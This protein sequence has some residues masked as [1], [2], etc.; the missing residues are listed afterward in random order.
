MLHNVL[1]FNDSKEYRD[2]HGYQTMPTEHL[3]QLIDARV[4]RKDYTH[5]SRDVC[6]Q[7]LLTQI[8][9]ATSKGRKAFSFSPKDMQ[10]PFNIEEIKYYAG[11]ISIRKAEDG[12]RWWVYMSCHTYLASLIRPRSSY[13]N[14]VLTPAPAN[15]PTSSYVCKQTTQR[16]EMVK[17]CTITTTKDHVC[18]IYIP[19]I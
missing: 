9:Y 14:N 6:R 18:M 3:F 19:W 1:A 11:T 7:I 15:N 17:W 8:W 13:Y 4:Q 12:G 10:R 16:F 5:N 2:G